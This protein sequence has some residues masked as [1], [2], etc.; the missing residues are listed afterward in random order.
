MF[1]SKLI[2]SKINQYSWRRNNRHNFTNI[3]CEFSFHEVTVGNMTYGNIKYLNHSKQNLHLKIGSY[4]SIA[5]EV[6]FILGSDHEFTHL[7]TYPF[8]SKMQNENEAV[9]KGD[10]IVKDD[11][12]IGYRSIILSGVII[13]QGAII[14]AHSVVTK[15][16]PP[17]AIVGGNPAKIIKMRFTEY[18][19]EKLMKFNF[20]DLKMYKIDLLY[21]KI[22]NENV[23]EIIRGVMNK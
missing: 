13:G 14:G 21:T 19:V 11:V 5:P 3:N 23:D 2:G 12:W 7:S 20:S 15:D 8:K 10:I 9:S 6:V 4:C 18:I 16:V 1:L 17:Y 22:T